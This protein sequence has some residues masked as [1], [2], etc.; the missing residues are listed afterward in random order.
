MS[1][2]PRFL[3]PV[4]SRRTSAKLAA[5]GTAGRRGPSAAA[6]RLRGDAAAAFSLRAGP[7]AVVSAGLHAAALAAALGALG[8]W[9]A[10]QGP[11]APIATVALISA[12]EFEALG[13][14]APSTPPDAGSGPRPLASTEIARPATDLPPAPAPATA[15]TP[16][17]SALPP[18]EHP[19]AAALPDA[20][21]AAPSAP[22]AVAAVDDAPHVGAAVG[23][24]AM[25]ADATA[26]VPPAPT[27]RPAGLGRRPAP[28]AGARRPKPAEAS[29]VAA[30]RSGGDGGGDSRAHAGGTAGAGPTDPAPDAAAS[31]LDA[32]VVG[33][34]RARYRGEV[35]RRIERAKRAGSGGEGVGAARIELI[36]DARGGLVGATLAESSGLAI[37]DAAALSTVRRAAPFPPPPPELSTGPLVLQVTFR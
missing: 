30:V 7:G 10:S 17:P 35:S 22:P 24:T 37:R 18:A 1:A 12:G 14:R 36:I 25:G 28:V 8:A 6:G 34:A 3:A 5:D 11:A 27:A 13:S 26:T 16:R 21:P 15:E 29:A 4:G 32:A 19:A 33:A 23:E 9:P 31:R 2:H 20:A